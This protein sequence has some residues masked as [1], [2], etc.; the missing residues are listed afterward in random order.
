M[1]QIA[2]KP[3]GGIRKE[4]LNFDVQYKADSVFVFGRKARLTIRLNTDIF[5]QK[6]QLLGASAQKPPGS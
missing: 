3:R 4:G 1:A 6:L 2:L 5:G